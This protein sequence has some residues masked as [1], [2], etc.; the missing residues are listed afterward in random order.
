MGRVKGMEQAVN[1]GQEAQ[2]PGDKV[3]VLEE[4]QQRQIENHRGG[5]RHP[6]AFVAALLF[7]FVHQQAM[8]VVNG[9][10]GEHDDVGAGEVGVGL[11]EAQHASD[12]EGGGK[13][14]ADKAEVDLAAE[15]HD[16]DGDNEEQ[17]DDQL[18]THNNSSFYL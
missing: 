2:A 15:K 6:G 11:V 9:D 17:G 3:P 5:N 12:T 18:G 4:K 8:G 14:H 7:A 1:D 10:G 13:E 16:D